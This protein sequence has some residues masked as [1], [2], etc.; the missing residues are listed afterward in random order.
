MKKYFIVVAML[1][2]AIIGVAQAQPKQKEKDYAPT[3][4]EMADMMKEMQ[5]AM[6]EISPE[7]KKVMDSMGIKMPDFNQTKKKVA[8]ISDKQLAEAWE[9]ENLVVPKRDATRIASIPKKI[10]SD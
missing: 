6:D 5:E 2:V 3:Q 4:K 1:F 7:D 9:D 10:T 8:G